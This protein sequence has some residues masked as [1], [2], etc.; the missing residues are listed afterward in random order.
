MWGRWK[1]MGLKGKDKGGW[2]RT[3]RERRRR[4]TDRNRWMGRKGRGRTG[5]WRGKRR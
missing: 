3:G 1:R 5:R 2:G 4:A